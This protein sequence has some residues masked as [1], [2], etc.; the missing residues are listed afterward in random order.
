MLGSSGHV[1][2]VKYL[3]STR[4]SWPWLPMLITMSGLVV[5]GNKGLERK[6]ARERGHFG[7]ELDNV[8]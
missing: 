2:G 7:D 1:T 8:A 4:E 3:L 5:L 6:V